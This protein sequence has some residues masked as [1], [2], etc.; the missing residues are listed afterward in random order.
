M[1]QRLTIEVESHLRNPANAEQSLATS[2]LR[3]LL[4]KRHRE[5]FSRTI[6][7]DHVISQAKYLKDWK[8]EQRP[9]GLFKEQKVNIVYDL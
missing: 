5:L 8:L 3:V 6:W 9:Q 2:E 1:V 4:N 7:Y